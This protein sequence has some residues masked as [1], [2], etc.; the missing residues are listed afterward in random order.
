L[1]ANGPRKF[2]SNTERK[3]DKKEEEDEEERRAREQK[4]NEQLQKQV[5]KEREMEERMQKEQAETA[6]TAKKVFSFRDAPRETPAEVQPRQEEPVRFG[7]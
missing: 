3:S 5:E 6:V 1:S 4:A 2:F 7:F